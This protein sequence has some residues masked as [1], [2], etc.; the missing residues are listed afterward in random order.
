MS[1]YRLKGT[2]GPVTNRSWPLENRAIIGGDAGATIHLDSETVASSHAELTVGEGQISLKLIAE[3]G[4]L[5]VNGAPV[6]ET[7]LSSG[8][9]IRIGNCRWML[10]APGLRPQKVLT[11]D[12]VRKRNR[13]LPWVIVGGLAAAGATAWWLGYLPF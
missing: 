10:Q 8:D 7:L 11:E 2:A 5:F 9:E 6:K 12:A 13:W 1:T 3:G 4:E